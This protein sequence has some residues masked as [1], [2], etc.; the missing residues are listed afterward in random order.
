MSLAESGLEIALE[1]VLDLGEM[2]FL[3][4]VLD[5]AT[6]KAEVF[7]FNDIGSREGLLMSDGEC[8]HIGNGCDYDDKQLY[9]SVAQ[10]ILGTYDNFDFI[11]SDWIEQIL[12]L[13]TVHCKAIYTELEFGVMYRHIIQSVNSTSRSIYSLLKA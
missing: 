3:I 4:S 7:L 5:E 9:Y 8:E 10:I 11:N 1:L 6:G 13:C 2:W 12:K